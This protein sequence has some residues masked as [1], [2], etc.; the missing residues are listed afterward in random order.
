MGSGYISLG[1]ASI[2]GYYPGTSSPMEQSISKIAILSGGQ[3]Y[4]PGTVRINPG[5]STGTPCFISTGVDANG[6]IVS[7]TFSAHGTQFDADVPSNQIQ[8]YYSGTT[9][10]QT[11]TITGISV[12][13]SGNISKCQ[14]GMT[15]VSQPA[16]SPSFQAVVTNVSS[17]GAITAVQIISN[18]G[19]FVA[20]PSLVVS[21]GTCTCNGLAGNVP[22]NLQG[23]VRP[24]VARGA[25]FSATRAYGVIFQGKIP[26]IVISNLRDTQTAD[27]LA[28]RVKTSCGAGLA[29][30]FGASAAWNQST[31]TVAT[32][33]QPNSTVP[34][35]TMCYLEFNLS[36]PLPSQFS[37]N[38]LISSL[39]IVVSPIPMTKGALNA[40]PLLIAGFQN[41]SVVSGSNTG[42]G[43]QTTIT[44]QLLPIASLFAGELLTFTGQ[45]HKNSPHSE[46]KP[47]LTS[48]PIMMDISRFDRQP[49][50]EQS[51]H[52]YLNIT[53]LYSVRQNCRMA[54]EWNPRWSISQ[55]ILQQRH[56]RFLICSDKPQRGT[57]QS[58]HFC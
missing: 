7:A 10:V 34:A 37:P 39:G 11:N 25:A 18:G 46:I 47:K 58:S 14:V 38:V 26:G 54:S 50:R 24:L 31:G 42:Q 13:N 44:V 28:I 33:Q 27:N 51:K 17:S 22:G 16:G 35:G 3:N 41:T 4:L 1:T 23:C 29:N 12:S 5:P 15:L 32:A 49:D 30:A 43:A 48:S 56:I 8:V 36:N 57:A 21:S 9:T 20:D 45:H 52:S 6:T 2:L 19:G 53:W 55:H 40:A